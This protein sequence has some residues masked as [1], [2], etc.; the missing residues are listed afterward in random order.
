MT[1]GSDAS[2]LPGLLVFLRARAMQSIIFAAFAFVAVAVFFF[3]QS[4]K[5]VRLVSYVDL[6]GIANE[7]YPNRARFSPQDLLARETVEIV[8]KTFEIDARSLHQ[9]LAVDYGSMALSGVLRRHE[10]FLAQKGLRPAE[11]EAQ[12]AQFASDLRSLSRRG[13]LLSLEFGRLGVSPQ[14][15]ADIIRAVPRVWNENYR[16][17]FRIIEDKSLKLAGSGRPEVDFGSIVGV[18]AADMSINAMQKVL[19]IL[20]EDPRTFSIMSGRQMTAGE[21]KAEI[22]RFNALHFRQV[23]ASVAA[24]DDPLE[25]AA[26]YVREAKLQAQEVQSKLVMLDK[27][28]MDIQRRKEPVETEGSGAA[29]KSADVLQMGDG[30]LRQVLDLHERASSTEYLRRMFEL[31]RAL[32]EEYASLVTNVERLSRVGS[33]APRIAGSDLKT[34]EKRM[35]SLVDDY[36]ELLQGARVKL[37][38]DHETFYES[39]GMPIQR[40]SSFRLSTIIALS[41]AAA[42]AAAC[43]WLGASWL[44]GRR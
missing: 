21:L 34:V 43:L 19:T 22:S 3:S 11:I 7:V 17:K 8:A 38:N 32:Q 35:G 12:N 2:T 6:K 44:F 20:E 15:A 9:A 18:V 23:L 33:P 13:L 30:V 16:T 41:L 5:Q 10:V 14:K 42:F 25:I 4:E 31:R 26:G 36:V 28:I 29:G 24:H 27:T 40:T 1:A 37:A 39:V